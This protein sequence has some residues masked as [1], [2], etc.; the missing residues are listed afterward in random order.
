MK[1]YDAVPLVK[2]FEHF[3]RLPGIGR[4]TAQRL[5]YS[6]LEMDEKV[7]KDFAECMINVKKSIHYCKLCCNFTD[8]DICPIC[9]DPERDTSKICIVEDPKDVKAFERAKEYNALYH[10]IHGVISPLNGIGPDQLHLKELVDRLSSGKIKEVILATNP[11]V[12]GEATSLYIS[13]LLK[14][15]GVKVSR[16]AYGIPLGAVLEYTDGETLRRAINDRIEM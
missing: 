13:K 9:S 8:R 10:V 1:D 3:E 7:V 12:E 5:A 4:K 2:L 6:I 15:M 11:T 14:P 16:I